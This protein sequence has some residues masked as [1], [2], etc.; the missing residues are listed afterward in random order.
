MRTLALALAA[1]TLSGCVAAHVA[2][3][4][5]DDGDGLLTD[6]EIAEGTDPSNPDSDGDGHLDGD[7]VAGGFDPLDAMSHPYKG[8]YHTDQGCRDEPHRPTGDDV[9]DI[10]AEFFGDDQYGDRFAS[11]DFCRKVILLKSGAFT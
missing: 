9:G 7:E 5:D 8:G 11:L 2:L 3:S 1:L 10:T 4:L 6:E